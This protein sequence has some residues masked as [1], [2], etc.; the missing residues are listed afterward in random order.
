MRRLISTATAL[1]LASAAPV[2]AFTP[3]AGLSGTPHDF[4]DATR[5]VDTTTPGLCTACHTPHS[6]I[7]QRVLWNH[8]LSTQ[9]SWT[10]T[11]SKT[12]NGTTLPT[13]NN[14]WGGPTVKCLSCHDGTVA[15]GDIN[16]FDEGNVTDLGIL[17]VGAALDANGKIQETGFVIGNGGNMDK[18][19]PVAIPFP[20]G[21]TADTYNSVTNSTTAANSGWQATPETNG[22]LLYEEVG[23]DIV[24]I[25]ATADI[26]DN[27]KLGIECTSC[28][29]PHNK[30]PGN[31]DAGD[32]FLRGQLTGN[33]TSYICLK[34]HNK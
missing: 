24:R 8:T 29:D 10:W 32:L 11:D 34:C 33:T 27:T 26:T 25:A 23:G 4:T 21:G 13:I 16:W 1:L 2:W 3:G 30:M 9:A 18:N 7:S 5:Y 19:H 12:A 14:T 6:A 22:I 15:V 28:H 17:S 31:P 20:Y